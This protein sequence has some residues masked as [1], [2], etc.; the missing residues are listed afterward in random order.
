MDSPPHEK[1]SRREREIMHA[2]HALGDRASVEEVVP[3]DVVLFEQGDIIPAD[4][5]LIESLSLRVDNST[6]TG[7]SMP[8][9]RDI[10]PSQEEALLRSRNILLAGMLHCVISAANWSW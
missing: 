10:G 3:G 5:R 2:L 4:C 9:G 8:Q 7:E 6:V 1:L